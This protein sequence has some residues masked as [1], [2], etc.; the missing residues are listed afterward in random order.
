MSNRQSTPYP[1]ITTLSLYLSLSRSLSL[2][3]HFLLTSFFPL[4]L[5]FLSECMQLFYKCA[6]DMDPKVCQ[7]TMCARPSSFFFHVC[8]FS[9]VT[10][11]LR[12]FI[13]LSSFVHSIAVSAL[14][15]STIGRCHH[16]NHF[17]LELSAVFVNGS[18]RGIEVRLHTIM[19]TGTKSEQQCTLST[20][21]SH[22]DHIQMDR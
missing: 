8:R 16:I 6:L 3:L 13:T 20:L 14:H 4:Y 15:A 11:E 10:K 7:Y 1:F 9:K 17:C 22:S 21:T 2:L 12:I 5:F 18:V 19:Y